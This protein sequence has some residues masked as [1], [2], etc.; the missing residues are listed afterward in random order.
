MVGELPGMTRRLY[1]LYTETFVSL[2]RLEMEKVNTIS[3][4]SMWVMR[5]DL[6]EFKFFAKTELG[7]EK[8]RHLDKVMEVAKSDPRMAHRL[9]EQHAL[10]D[11]DAVI[12][13]H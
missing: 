6:P 7:P 4:L 5:A 9:H 10:M 3:E 2:E 11:G 1:E 13:E 8:A 12:G